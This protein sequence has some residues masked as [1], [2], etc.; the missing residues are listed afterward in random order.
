MD[1]EK[2]LLNLLDDVRL[3]QCLK[4]ML[5]AD[6]LAYKFLSD[7]NS[8]LISIELPE[9]GLFDK[10]LSACG[11]PEDNTYLLTLSAETGDYQQEPFCRSYCLDE[12]LRVQ[13]NE[14]SIDDF[15]KWLIAES[16]EINK[17]IPAK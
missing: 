16:I 1:D 14:Q 5:E 3:M 8:D 6:L 2:R 15:L 9:L 17:R 4:A 11:I 7:I 12:W 13:D 10:V